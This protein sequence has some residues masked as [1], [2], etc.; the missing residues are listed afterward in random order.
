MPFVLIRDVC[1]AI[2]VVFCLT[3]SL[4][5]AQI[6]EGQQAHVVFDIRLDKLR[7]YTDAHGIDLNQMLSEMS[8]R[9]FDPELVAGVSR[10]FGA[11]QLP[12]DEETGRAM[13]QMMMGPG[14]IRQPDRSDEKMSPESEIEEPDGELRSSDGFSHVGFRRSIRRQDPDLPVNFFVRVKFSNEQAAAKFSE[15]AFENASEVQVGRQSFLHPGGGAPG[16]F[17]MHMIDATTFEAGTE[18]YLTVT[19]RR[20]LF[21]DRLKAAWGGM[22]DEA[23]RIALDLESV[24]EMLKSV[25]EEAKAAGPPAM[26]GMMDLVMKVST[27][28][29]SMDLQTDNLMSLIMTGRDESQ[30]EELRSG[31]DALLGMAKMMGGQGVGELGDMS[32]EMGAAA[33]EMLQSL[34]ATRQGNEVSILISRPAGF[35]DAVDKGMLA[36]QAAAV[37]V[38]RKNQIRQVALGIH[39]YYDVH[40][41]FPFQPRGNASENLNWRARISP[42]V[43]GPTL[44]LTQPFD[45]SVNAAFGDEM[46]E[47][48]GDDGSTAHVCW[49]EA[50][51][52]ADRFE[53]IADGTSMTIMLLEHPEGMPWLEPANLTEDE[54]IELITGIAEDE[55]LLAAFYDGSV[56]ELRSGLTAEEIRP[57]LTHRG[58]ELVDRDVLNDKR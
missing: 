40:R 10:I 33:S 42:F 39:N 55:T 43:E 49:I 47:A 19:N 58:G 51:D 22:P 57:F 15:L 28:R 48:F 26:G 12:P 14:E 31:L 4:A 50:N 2:A 29:Y 36:M 24:D 45:A 8:G 18:D 9:E 13:S 3:P 44:D 37:E 32:P 21:T 23:I 20:S 35:D 53:G 17:L 52:A 56:I 7:D 38:D 1:L 16:N 34:R 54:A 27:V 11:I 5:P 41:R 46:P 30:A 6:A 25:V